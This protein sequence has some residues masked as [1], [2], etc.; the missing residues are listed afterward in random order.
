MNECD[1][2]LA[3]IKAYYIVQSISNQNKFHVLFRIN[4]MVF[5]EFFCLL[6]NQT[7]FCL[8]A[9]KMKIVRGIGLY[10]CSLTIVIMKKKI[11]KKNPKYN[12]QAIP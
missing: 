11:I 5:V 4:V 8:V 7:E 9:N 12:S 10:A 3:W 2:C 1:L 6:W